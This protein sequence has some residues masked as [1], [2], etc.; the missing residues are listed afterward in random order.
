MN[1]EKKKRY[2]LTTAKDIMQIVAGATILGFPIAI[3]E[4][5]QNLSKSMSWTSFIPNSGMVT[6][7]F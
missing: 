2:I 7:F 5:V 1:K 6:V 4:D 3:T